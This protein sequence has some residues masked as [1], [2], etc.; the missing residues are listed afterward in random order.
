MLARCIEAVDDE[1][2]WGRESVLRQRRSERKKGFLHKTESLHCRVSRAAIADVRDRGR[3]DLGSVAARQAT[4]APLRV[5]C[6]IFTGTSG[7]PA[8]G[9][10]YAWRIDA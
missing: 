8:K 5:V 6:A 3:Y 10:L 9:P 1:D 4:W 2:W 7:R